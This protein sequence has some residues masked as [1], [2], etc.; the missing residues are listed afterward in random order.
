MRNKKLMDELIQ[1]VREHNKKVKRLARKSALSYKA[2]D[3]NIIVLEDFS[4]FL[5]NTF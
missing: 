5:S 2:K 1:R 3:N 4:L